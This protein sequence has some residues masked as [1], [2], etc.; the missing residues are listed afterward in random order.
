MQT[1]ARFE[2]RSIN[3]HLI[4]LYLLID[5]CYRSQ[6][7][8]IN[9]IAPCFPYA[10][11]DKK[12]DRG[13]ISAKLVIN[14]IFSAGARRLVSMDLHA[15]QEQGFTDQ[16]FDNIYCINIIIPYL[17]T[18]TDGNSDK[19]ILV[20]PDAGGVKRITKY[21]EK[22]HLDYVMLHKQRNYSLLNVVESSML[23]GNPDILSKAKGKIAIVIDDMMDTCGTMAAGVQTLIDNG[24]T[25]V[26]LVAT[27]GIFSGDAIVKLNECE[28]I[29]EVIVTNTICQQYNLEQCSKL[30]V[31]DTSPLLS[32]VIRRILCDDSISELF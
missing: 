31:I 30:H 11:S 24:I 25:R 2:E 28:A 9:V 1:G 14:Q 26:I 13:P 20:S 15:G 32:E 19:Y 6:A 21:A 10:R 7:N 23:L 8:S 29:L 22:L 16:P 27:H 5:G 3:D 12:D 18:L 17:K 4:E